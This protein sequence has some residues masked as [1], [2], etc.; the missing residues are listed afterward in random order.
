MST[1]IK[2]EFE[3][4]KKLILKKHENTKHGNDEKKKG[5]EENQKTDKAEEKCKECE[6]CESCEKCDFIKNAEHC[7][8]CKEL[9]FNW[10]SVQCGLT[11][12][13]WKKEKTNN[14]TRKPRTGLPRQSV[15]RIPGHRPVEFSPP[16]CNYIDCWNVLVIDR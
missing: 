11:S 8:M 6:R 13:W 10:A 4:N 5:N 1:W 2:C 7:D 14:Q 9:M 16:V 15:R 3:T 12:E